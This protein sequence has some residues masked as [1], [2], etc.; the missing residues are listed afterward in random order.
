MT[1]LLHGDLG[2]SP[3]SHLP[4]IQQIG[5]YLPATI[6]L[7]ITALIISILIGIPVGVLSALWKDRKIDYPIRVLYLSG[8][9]SPPFLLALIFQLLISYY[10]KLLPSSGRLSPGLNPPTHITGLYTIDSLLTGNWVDLQNSVIHLILPAVALALLSFSIIAR[11]TRS[12]MLET[13]EKD[14]VRTARSKGLP[15]IWVTYKHTLR[16]AL[17]STVTV[18]GF[19]VQLLLSGT[20]VVETIFFWPGL[21]YYTTQAILSLDF[22]SIMGVTIVFTIIVIV[23]N[24]ITDVVYGVLDPRVRLG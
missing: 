16:N 3:V 11:I 1:D 8:I 24:L 6:E 2:I 13:M 15:K 14:Y 7:S 5:N 19:T 12:S 21:G 18:I 23:T 20:I 4:V 17:I 22:P 9:A 10:F